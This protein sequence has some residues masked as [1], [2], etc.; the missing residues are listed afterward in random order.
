MHIDVLGSFVALFLQLVSMSG[1][2]L[3]I[4]D[5]RCGGKNYAFGS[6]HEAFVLPLL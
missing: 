1:S 4:Q 3:K 2:W 6:Q 5:S